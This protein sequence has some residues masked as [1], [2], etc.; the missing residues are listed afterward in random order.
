[1]KHH[2][3]E[4]DYLWNP[5]TRACKTDEYLKNYVYMK[6]LNDGLVI[7]FDDFI[8]VVAKSKDKQLEIVAISSNDKKVI[9]KLHYYICTLFISNHFVIKNS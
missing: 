7:I 3:C 8:D 4:K 2:P 6:N 9:Y 5:S 1:M